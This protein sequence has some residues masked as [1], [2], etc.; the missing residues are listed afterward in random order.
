MS[1]VL[2]NTPGVCIEGP[3]G[4]VEIEEGVICATRHLHVSPEEA[5]MLGLRDRDE[6]SVHVEG[7]R[8]LVFGEVIVRVH[9]EY[10]L[11]MHIDTD[12]ANAARLDQGAVGYIQ[13]VDVR[14]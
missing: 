7:E 10:R 11:D 1:G 6:I 5:L 9:P 4:R 3:A 13:S 14:T 12:E 8:A 2:H